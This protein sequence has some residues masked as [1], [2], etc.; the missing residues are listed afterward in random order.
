LNR[1]DHPKRHPDAISRFATIH[2]CGQTD[3]DDEC[4]VP[5]ALRSIESDALMILY[6]HWL[7][8]SDCRFMFELMNVVQ[9]ELIGRLERAVVY[10]DPPPLDTAGH[11]QSAQSVNRTTTATVRCFTRAV[12]VAY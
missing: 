12:R 1:R 5:R 4:S 6:E 3:G 11:Q 9:G 10:G 7:S 8:R 2:M